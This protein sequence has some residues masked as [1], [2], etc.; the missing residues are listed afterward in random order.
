MQT[1][2]IYVIVKRNEATAKNVL[3]PYCG[4]K[5]CL[6]VSVHELHHSAGCSKPSQRG[7][8]SWAGHGRALLLSK[9]H[10][11]SGLIHE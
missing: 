8:G 3:F 10:T 2:E 5:Q 9:G 11:L 4:K 1:G 7:M 6:Q